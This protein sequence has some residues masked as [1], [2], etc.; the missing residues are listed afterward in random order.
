[1][2][3]IFL[4]R[5]SGCS[6][7]FP[8]VVSLL[9]IVRFT[10]SDFVE[11][12]SEVVEINS[13]CVC[14]NF[15]YDE[16]GLGEIYFKFR[17]F[18]AKIGGV[19]KKVVRKGQ[20]DLVTIKIVITFATSHQNNDTM[21]KRPAL[22]RLTPKEEELMEYLWELGEASPRELSLKHPDP[23]PHVN[24]LATVLLRL[25][26]KRYVER[27]Q[28]NRGSAYRPLVA[29]EDYGRHRISNFVHR[30]FGDSYLSAVSAF[31]EE[32]KISE[33][34]LMTLLQTLQKK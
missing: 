25:E 27:V 19:T 20:K 14:N 12:E 13:E 8:I 30:Y 6:A 22:E 28:R 17:P 33:E 10:T 7:V 16:Q 3:R 29:K 32:E 18:K 11:I 24:T 9:R 26:E 5:H 1:M 4:C 23:Q 21:K 31:V 2:P 34:E 15:L